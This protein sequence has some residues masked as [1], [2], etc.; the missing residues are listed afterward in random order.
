MMNEEQK[1]FLLGMCQVELDTY[2]STIKMLEANKENTERFIQN[3]NTL[4]EII[5]ILF[6]ETERDS[7]CDAGPFDYGDP[8]RWY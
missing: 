4:N 8:T 3:R 1:K 6:N 5:S 7:F 2:N